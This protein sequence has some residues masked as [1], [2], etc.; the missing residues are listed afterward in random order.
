MKIMCKHLADLAAFIKIV[1]GEGGLEPRHIGVCIGRFFL[2][3]S[4]GL[5]FFFLHNNVLKKYIN[6]F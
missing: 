1:G 2:T 6:S 4:Y 3:P 5:G